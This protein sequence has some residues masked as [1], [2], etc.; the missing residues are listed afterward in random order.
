M[1]LGLKKCATANM[2][3]GKVVTKGSISVAS[4][5]VAEVDYGE[6]YKYLG[7]SQLFLTSA[8]KAKTRV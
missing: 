3:A 1:I 8:K 4:G 7:L 2:V 5:E 6:N